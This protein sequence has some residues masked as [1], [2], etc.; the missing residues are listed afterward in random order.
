MGKD[1]RHRPGHDQLVRRRHGGRRA[2]RHPQRRG[3]A[4]HPVGRRLRQDRRAPGRHGRQ[5]AG[6]HQPRE[7]RVLDQALHGPQVR[8]GRRGDE[9]RPLQ[10]RPRRPTATRACDVGGKKYSPPEISRDDPAEAQGAT[11]RRTWARRS[12]RRSSPSRRTSTTRSARPPRTPA[13]SPASKSCASSTSRP[14]PRWPT[15][16]TRRHDQTILVFDLGGGTFD[17]SILEVGDGVFEVKS[18]NGDT[19]LGGDDFDQR[20]HR[21]DGRASSSRARASTCAGPDGAAAAATRPPRRPR[22]SSRRRMQTRDQPAVHHGR[23]DRPQA[24]AT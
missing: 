21:L 23:R 24:P 3:R 20:D 22:S 6:R 11:P 9:D 17:I 2:D 8:R 4:H 12:P 13:R 19:H 15:G 1:D 14:R 10:G 18:T 7:H 16:S 5:A